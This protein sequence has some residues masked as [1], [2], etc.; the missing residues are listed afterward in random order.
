MSVHTFSR[1]RLLTTAAT[2]VPVAA[3]AACSNVPDDSAAASAGGSAGTI[4]IVGYATPAEA[5]KAVGAAW[6]KTSDGKGVSFQTS[7]GASGDQ[8]RSIAN[9]QKADFVHFSVTPDVTRLVEK[10]LVASNWDSGPHKGIVTTTTVTISV[11]SGNPLGITGWDDLVK[12]GVQI[13]TPNPSS[14]GSARWNILAAWAHV[15]A[16]G[17][18]E[19]EAGE[20]LSKVIKNTVALPGSGRDATTSFT[21]GTGNVLLSYE[22]EAIYARQ[23]DQSILDYVVPDDTLLIENPGAVTKSA[24]AKAKT[25]LD[26]VLT[27]PAQKIYAQY[28]FRPLVG[29]APSSVKGV[30]DAS[31]PFPEITHLFTI[32]KNFGG[33]KETNSKYFGD[34]G[35]VT[36][37]LSAAGK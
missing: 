33:W 13:V 7:Y 31:T 22:N 29:E 6:A 30:Q 17:G 23:K 2:A 16:Q 35:I 15:A 11:R 9:G 37:L 28:G 18:S 26:Y 32:D 34:N 21:G 5:N 14:S 19:K 1:R 8:S 12:S 24:T 25:W 4:R 3:L 27:E 10:G 36:K 20:F